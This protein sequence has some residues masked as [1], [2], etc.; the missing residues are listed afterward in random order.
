MSFNKIVKPYESNYT[1]GTYQY[2]TIDC[3]ANFIKEEFIK[4]L[5]SSKKIQVVAKLEVLQDIQLRL[6]SFGIPSSVDGGI[7][8]RGSNL[9]T[10]KRLNRETTQLLSSYSY[11]YDILNSKVLDN[12]SLIDILKLIGDSKEQITPYPF[13][14]SDMSF[15]FSGE[16]YY[17]LT[18][19]I[20]TYLRFNTINTTSQIK[21]FALNQFNKQALINSDKEALHTQLSNWIQDL[22]LIKRKLLSHLIHHQ[23]INEHKARTK[24]LAALDLL[25]ESR[26]KVYEYISLYGNE[27]AQKPALFSLDKG[28]KEKF[29]AWTILQNEIGLEGITTDALIDVLNAKQDEANRIYKH[30]IQVIQ[31]GLKSLNGYNS[32]NQNLINDIQSLSDIIT[33]INTTQLFASKIEDNAKSIFI[34]IERIDQLIDSLYL[35]TQCR[36]IDGILEWY[37]LRSNLDKGVLSF[38]SQLSNTPVDE[39]KHQFDYYYF[40]QLLKQ[41][42]YSY[43]YKSEDL[44]FKLK[45]A[46]NEVETLIL[47]ANQ[48]ALNQSINGLKSS[49][50]STYKKVLDNSCPLSEFKTHINNIAYVRLDQQVLDSNQADD[51]TLICIDRDLTQVNSTYNLYS[52]NNAQHSAQSSIYRAITIS[53][54]LSNTPISR[55]LEVAKAL[56]TN[57]FPLLDIAIGYQFKNKNVLNLIH[58]HWQD[59]VSSALKKASGKEFVIQTV[60]D[61]TNFFLS[62]DRPLFIL[63]QDQIINIRCVD[64]G[65]MAHTT[66]ELE[67]VGFKLL[68]TPSANFV[69][70]INQTI[71]SILSEL[72]LIPNRSTPAKF[73]ID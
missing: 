32:Q 54:E 57:L 16:E 51:L 22:S 59:D 66:Q 26:H 7:L 12:W 25:N 63:L 71:S 15:A 69:S 44:G 34:K 11:T 28:K 36:D 18:K 8:E 49:S 50:K 17:D 19:V 55:Q 3:I 27:G 29:E 31:N 14:V 41:I 70:N 58:R 61:L 52:I 68:S 1:P 10:S 4:A 65:W 73:G 38:L 39:W 42:D 47:K 45:N 64:L 72:E 53:E 40:N 2:N 46:I 30:N 56:A 9:D 23:E 60:D 62:T 21:E 6:K 37:Q 67:D 13:M 35:L 33:Q 24:K 43:L 5:P 20:R 48:N